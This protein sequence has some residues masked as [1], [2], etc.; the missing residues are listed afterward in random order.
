LHGVIGADHHW[1][2]VHWVTAAARTPRGK[3]ARRASPRSMLDFASDREILISFYQI[4]PNVAKCPQGQGMI[5]FM[6]KIYQ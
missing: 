3:N 5:F 2:V 6:P 4:A 1:Q